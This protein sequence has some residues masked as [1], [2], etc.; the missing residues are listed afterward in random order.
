[1][2]NAIAI[3]RVPLREIEHYLRIEV[4]KNQYDQEVVLNRIHRGLSEK[5]IYR[6]TVGGQIAGI[7]T[8]CDSMQKLEELY[9]SPERRALGLA[10]RLVM[11]INPVSAVVASQNQ[12]AIRLFESLGYKACPTDILQERLHF[13]KNGHSPFFTLTDP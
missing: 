13:V 10:K 11:T 3:E 1:M 5:T 9:I 12:A 2:F 8:Y 7:A 6:I 4:R